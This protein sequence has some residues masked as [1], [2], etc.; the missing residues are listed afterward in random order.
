LFLFLNFVLFHYR[1]QFIAEPN[2]YLSIYNK[3]LNKTIQ[4]PTQP[5]QYLQQVHQQQQQQHHQ[6]YQQQQ[7]KKEE[8]VIRN[9]NANSNISNINGKKNADVNDISNVMKTSEQPICSS[10]NS[11]T[12]LS[13]ISNVSGVVVA[14]EQVATI[15]TVVDVT[16]KSL[17][18][19]VEKH[20]ST[21]IT[22]SVVQDELDFDDMF[23]TNRVS[24]KHFY[25]FLSFFI[26][27]FVFNSKKKR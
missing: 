1:Q 20:D 14:K 9:S 5:I 22:T 7:Q 15:N 13:D 3:H 23:I 24:S 6:Q 2:N 11:S 8:Q 26:I 12:L 17:N 25:F 16:T 18:T 19:S 21:T 10:S 4:P 27:F